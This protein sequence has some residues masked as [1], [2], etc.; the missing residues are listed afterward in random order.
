MP[1]PIKPPHLPFLIFQTGLT[2][3][4]RPAL[5]VFLPQLPKCWDYRQELLYPATTHNSLLLFVSLRQDQIS[6][7]LLIQSKITLN[8]KSSSLLSFRSVSQS[9]VKCS[10]RDQ[11]QDFLHSRQALYQVSYT[12]NPNVSNSSTVTT[13][14]LPRRYWQGTYHKQGQLL[15]ERVEVSRDPR[16]FFFHPAVVST[17]FL[18]LLGD[19]GSPGLSPDTP[20][21]QLVLP[22]YREKKRQL[23][24]KATEFLPLGLSRSL[25]FLLADHSRTCGEKWKEW[26][27]RLLPELGRRHNNE[28]LLTGSSLGLQASCM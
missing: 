24:L 25:Q 7:E 22:F 21:Q 5:M 19:P 11:T 2:L 4:C 14:F 9:L 20:S 13:D 6:L 27:E 8:F 12:S 1:L 26:T 10:G 15:P 17:I 3:Q 23:R 16:T 28:A 18:R